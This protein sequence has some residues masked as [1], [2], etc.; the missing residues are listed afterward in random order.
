LLFVVLTLSAEIVK[1]L[2]NTFVIPE[3][4]K[5]LLVGGVTAVEIGV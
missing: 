5:K 4:Q 2:N 3:T 1:L